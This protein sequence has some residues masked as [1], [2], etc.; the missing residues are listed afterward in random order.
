[1]DN[2]LE[3]LQKYGIVILLVISTITMFKSCSMDR[4]ITKLEKKQ[5][6]LEVYDSVL[7]QS[8]PVTYNQVDSITKKRLFEFMVYSNDLNR[9]K[10]TL[11]K[12][13]TMTK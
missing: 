5:E 6:L 9:G 2:I 13:Q 10:T 7:Q 12:I 8:R 4:D 1:M 3:Y 11:S